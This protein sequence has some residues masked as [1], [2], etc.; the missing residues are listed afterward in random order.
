MHKN[1][2]S[3]ERD[4]H[5]ERRQYLRHQYPWGERGIVELDGKTFPLLDICLHGLRS[6][7]GMDMALVEGATVNAT[8]RFAT[9]KELAQSGTIVRRQGDLNESSCYVRAGLF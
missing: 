4:K 5:P 9:G 7:I 2:M 6:D 3:N 8:I 1:A